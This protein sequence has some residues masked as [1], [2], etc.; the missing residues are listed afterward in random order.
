M[1]VLARAMGVIGDDYVVLA[2][3][4]RGL[5][6]SG[7]LIGIDGSNEIADA[8]AVFEWLRDRPD[9]ADGRSAP[10]DLLRRRRCAQFTGRR[11]AVGRAGGRR[12]LDR[13]VLRVDAARARQVGVI[14]GH[15]AAAAEGRL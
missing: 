9:V 6:Q 1:V 8:R 12:D 15:C 11:R 14:G 4:A 7:G 2:Y 13:P 10:G 3:D 5:G